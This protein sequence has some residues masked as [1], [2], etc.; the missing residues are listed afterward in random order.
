MLNRVK[1][2]DGWRVKLSRTRLIIPLK[3]LRALILSASHTYGLFSQDKLDRYGL[4]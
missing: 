4:Q 2:T 1:N 3:D